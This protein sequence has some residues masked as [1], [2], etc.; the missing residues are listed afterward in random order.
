MAAPLLGTALMQAVLSTGTECSQISIPVQAEAARACLN[1]KPA[2][3][4]KFVFLLCA[5]LA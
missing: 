3:M 2:E 5:T 4:H 1:P